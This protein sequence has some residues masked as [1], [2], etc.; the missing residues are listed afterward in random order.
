[1]ATALT[2]H[3]DARV[4]RLEAVKKAAYR[5][6]GRASISID[7]PEPTHVCVTL[8]GIS[9]DEESASL[10]RE[11]RSE[12]LDQELRE[13]VARE[14]EA[15]RNLILLQAFSKTGLLGGTTESADFRSDPL[16]LAS[17]ERE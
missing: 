13:V 11:F 8:G 16:G 10:E 15:A 14:T 3:F 6:A 12:V 1:M 4:F 9:N 2:L 7:V 5:F 17:A